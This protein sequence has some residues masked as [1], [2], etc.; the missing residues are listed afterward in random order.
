[1]SL[2]R[3]MD[4][5][6]SLREATQVLPPPPPPPM[7]DA[8]RRADGQTA[9]L[10]PTTNPGTPLLTQPAPAPVAKRSRVWKWVA[11]GAAVAG[12]GAA[13]TLGVM[14]NGASDELRRMERPQ[15]EAQAL[16]DRA[17]GMALGANVAWGIAAGAAVTAV[18]LFVTE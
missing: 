15:A 13:T 11:G 17:Q 16:H 6:I 3:A 2:S 10:T 18:I 5:T 7:V 4:M 14:A 9:T 1:M 8:P 12:A